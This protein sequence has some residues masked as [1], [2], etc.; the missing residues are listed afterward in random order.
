M[1]PL[2][3]AVEAGRG[4]RAGG[5]REALETYG[6]RLKSLEAIADSCA[7]VGRVYAIQAGREL[8][9]IVTPDI[10]TDAVAEQLAIDIASRIERELQ[11]PGHIRVTVIRETR[12][13]S[14]AR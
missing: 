5:R 13:M 9:V 1:A 10:V 2:G 6:Q 7:G 12:A 14:Y 3:E 11:Y 4:A 8:R